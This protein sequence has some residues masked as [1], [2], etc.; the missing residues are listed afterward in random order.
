MESHCETP[1]HPCFCWGIA[2][3]YKALIV[4]IGG[5]LR[6]N[7]DSTVAAAGATLLEVLSSGEPPSP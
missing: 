5:L 4:I 7:D 1:L 3:R 6:A 2:P